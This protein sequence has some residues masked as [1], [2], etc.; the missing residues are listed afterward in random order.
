MII[1]FKSQKRWYMVC[2]ELAQVQCTPD[3]LL[4]T[5]KREHKLPDHR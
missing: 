4:S 5:Q 3:E 1:F 2:M